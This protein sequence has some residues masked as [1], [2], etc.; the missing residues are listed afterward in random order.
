MLT[1]FQEVEDGLSSERLLAGQL[2]AEQA[3][4]TSARRT[5]E[6]ANNRYKAGLVTYLEVAV[7]QSAALQNEQNVLELQGQRL[8]AQVALVKALG[9]GWQSSDVNL[10][11]GTK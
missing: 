7:A 8:A 5:Q 2:E 3:A 4:L 1:A 10:A 9:G 11:S 6:I